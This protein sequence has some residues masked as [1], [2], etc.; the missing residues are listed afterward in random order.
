VTD[1]RIINVPG[2]VPHGSGL[3][4][5]PAASKAGSHNPFRVTILLQA[6]SLAWSQDK[7][8]SPRV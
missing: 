7:E 6:E 3:D 4:G 2:I 1:E 5:I 8:H